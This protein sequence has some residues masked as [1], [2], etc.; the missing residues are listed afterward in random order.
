MALGVDAMFC[1]ARLRMRCCNCWINHAAGRYRHVTRVN[2]SGWPH[3]TSAYFPLSPT[4]TSHQATMSEPPDGKPEVSR[5]P[6][7]TF[8]LG[9]RYS[10]AKHDGF[11]ACSVVFKPTAR[12][13]NDLFGLKRDRSDRFWVVVGGTQDKPVLYT[14]RCVATEPELCPSLTDDTVWRRGPCSA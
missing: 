1:A 6:T 10:P 3:A 11:H 13:H 14:D 8:D 7:P 12:F 2:Q 4:T 9:D 5:E